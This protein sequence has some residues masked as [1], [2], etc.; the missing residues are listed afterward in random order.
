MTTD[1]KAPLLAG[2]YR[3]IRRL[4]TGGA[5]TVLLA[6]D[7]RLGRRVAVKR[8]HADSPDDAARRFEREARLG[9]SLNHPNVVAV[10]DTTSD[11][12]GVLIVTEYVEGATLAQ[13]LRQGRLSSERALAVV[14]GVAAALDHAHRHGIVHRDVKPANVLMRPDGVVKLADLGIATATEAAEITRTGAMLGTPAYMAPEQLTGGRITLATDVY[15]L[16]A[17]AFECLSGRPARAGRTAMEVIHRVATQAAPDIRTVWPAAPGAVAELLS[18]AMARDPRERPRTAGTLAAELRA[19]L[20][21]AEATSPDDPPTRQG[22]A[23]TP[24]EPAPVPAPDPVTRPTPI[25]SP[26][27]QPARVRARRRTSRGTWAA[28]GALAVVALGALALFAWAGGSQDRAGGERAGPAAGGSSRDRA[29]SQDVDGA[30][31]ATTPR[32]RKRSDETAT[33][34]AG[35]PARR[36]TGRAGSAGPSAPPALLDGPAA[37]PEAAVRGLYE[38]AAADDFDDAWA[39]AGPGFRRQLG[40]YRSFRGTF[41][42]LQRVRFTRLETVEQGD[43]Q[44]ALAIGTTATHSDRVE[45]CT[46]SARTVRSAGSW[47]VDGVQIACRA[48]GM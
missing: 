11:D 10:F 34:A 18:R 39:L 33:R 32:G 28:L 15:G 25:A 23:T 4:G 26:S 44:A 21:P 47:L 36:G 38:R 37:T 41:A 16:A 8:M 20:E 13:A 2:R 22:V 48:Q 43:A 7:E 45:R 12:T 3:V 46:G 5:A 14:D 29:R 40:G 27:A 31:G 1:R 42:T 19:A 6:E 24:S 17:L 9:A 30:S 35:A